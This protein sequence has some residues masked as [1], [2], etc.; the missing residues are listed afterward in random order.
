MSFANYVSSAH[1]SDEVCHR[2]H[3][4]IKEMMNEFFQKLQ[5]ISQEFDYNEH[6]EMIYYN[7]TPTV[8]WCGAWVIV[9]SCPTYTT[10]G[11]LGGF[12]P[13]L[14]LI[15]LLI[16]DPNIKS[17]EVTV[18]DPDDGLNEKW[19]NEL[20]LILEKTI[21]CYEFAFKH[22]RD[23]MKERKEKAIKEAAAKYES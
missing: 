1:L 13:S 15:E 20:R 7:G 3:Q 5:T 2:I 21:P 11:K 18:I 22:E 19:E 8:S 10:E 23:L 16:K 17:T 14:D 12:T 6:Q 9:A 4:K